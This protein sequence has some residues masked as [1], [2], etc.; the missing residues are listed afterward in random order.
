MMT[1]QFLIQA[2]HNSLFFS[3]RRRP[4]FFSFPL[5][6][7]R[8]ATT[9][10]KHRNAHTHTHIYTHTHKHTHTHTRR[11]ASS[12]DL[13]ENKNANWSARKKLRNSLRQLKATIGCVNYRRVLATCGDK[14]T[15]RCLV[16]CTE[17]CFG[18]LRHNS[19]NGRNWI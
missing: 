4:F 18:N 19:G 8:L 13:L 7:N 3:F 1:K 9:E 15:L 17:P 14:A 16:S 10:C 6:V 5:R 11:N 12:K 2:E